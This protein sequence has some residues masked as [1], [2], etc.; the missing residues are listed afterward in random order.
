MDGIDKGTFGTIAVTNP[1]D[2]S[3]I[4]LQKMDRR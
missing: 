3:R 4:A 1:S 2:A